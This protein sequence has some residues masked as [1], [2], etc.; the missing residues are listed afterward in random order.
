MTFPQAH[1]YVTVIGDSYAQTERWQFGLR[2]TSGGVSN[3]ATADAIKPIVLKWW[4]G[5][6]APYSVNSNFGAPTTHRLTEIKCANIE[7]TGLYPPT[8]PSASSFI[9]PPQAGSAAPHAGMLAQGSMAMTLMT[10]I[11]R[12]LA[13]KGRVYLPPSIRYQPGTDGLLAAAEAQ[14]LADSFLNLIKEIN[15]D[16]LVGNVAVFSRGKGHPAPSANGKKIL[17]TYPDPGAMNLVTGIRVGRV[18]D[19]QRRRRRS[20]AEAPVTAA[21]TV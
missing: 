8:L 15:A 3:Q 9:V 20:L 12:G 21:G 19:T 7:T 4:V 5:T 18:V 2:L 1:Q 13:S 6:A 14:K 10:A 17:Y 11:P 16:A